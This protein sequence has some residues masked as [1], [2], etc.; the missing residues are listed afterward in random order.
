M[1]THIASGYILLEALEI[2]LS[3]QPDF[4]EEETEARVEC[5]AQGHTTGESRTK[6]P[7]RG[8]TH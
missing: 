6:S 8:L 7:L 3:L 4:T 5:F 2:G 1:H